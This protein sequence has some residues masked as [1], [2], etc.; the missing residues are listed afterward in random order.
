MKK[1]DNFADKHRK[2]GIPLP[3]IAV[4]P[5]ENM[6]FEHY[7]LRRECSYSVQDYVRENHEYWYKRLYLNK[8]INLRDVFKDRIDSSNLLTN[9]QK[10]DLY[11]SKTPKELWKKIRKD[12]LCRYDFINEVHF[13]NHEH[14]HASYAMYASPLKKEDTL[15]VTVDG[16]GDDANASIW[17]YEVDKLVC[18][19]KYTNFNIGRI[20]RHITLLLGMKPNEHEYKVMGLAPNA[21]KEYMNEA[22]K[23]FQNTWYFDDNDGE[24]KHYN[25]PEDLYFYFKERLE[26]FRFD[27][28]AGGL[29]KYAEIMLI[30]LVRYWSKKLSKRRVVI[31]GGVSL[32]IKA[33]MHIGELDCIDEIFVPASGGDES[34]CIASI[35]A[36]LDSL[37]ESNYINYMKDMYLGSYYSKREIEKDVEQFLV[38]KKYRVTYNVSNKVVAKLLAEGRIMAR[39]VGRMEFGARS[40]GN[41]AILANPNKKDIVRSINSKIK[42]R[43]FWMPFTP[44]IIDYMQDEYIVNKKKFKLPFMTIAT[45]TTKRGQKDIFGALHPADYTA[46]PQVVTQEGN[47]KYWDLID[48]FYKLTGIGAL[49]N[50]S[51]NISGLPICESPKDVFFVFENSLID[52]VL[53][54]DC[55]VEK[56]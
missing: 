37:G 55:L 8:R 22:L 19:K 51:L 6:D 11:N 48:E 24:I 9:E 5:S 33:N 38:G 28:I 2:A 45:L 25:L 44:S 12:E 17:T 49:L 52:A 23:V 30:A 50:T 31:S 29:Q 42:K 39:F 18:H 1:S 47:K 15:V 26:G 13:A 43:D 27:A 54:E 4:I 36:Y 20:Y 32:N 41:R 46:R 40:L 10:K 3:E 53:L 14:S 7:L 34:L 35:F 56:V 16:F 21:D